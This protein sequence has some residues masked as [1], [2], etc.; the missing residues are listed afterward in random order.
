MACGLRGGCVAH[1][2]DRD[3]NNAALPACKI[4]A[5]MQARSC[6]HE[7]NKIYIFQPHTG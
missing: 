4:Y 2:C 6:R 5:G 7:L 3:A 1:I